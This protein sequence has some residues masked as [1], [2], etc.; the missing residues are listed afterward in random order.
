MSETAISTPKG[1]GQTVCMCA[2]VFVSTAKDA[3]PCVLGLKPD[4]RRPSDMLHKSL[5]RKGPN[6]LWELYIWG[7]LQCQRKVLRKV[8]PRVRFFLLG[9][10]LQPPGAE[11]PKMAI[12]M[13]MCLGTTQLGTKN[14]P[15]GAVSLAK[16]PEEALSPQPVLN[17]KKFLQQQAGPGLTRSL[18]FA[19]GVFS[20]LGSFPTTFYSAQRFCFDPKMAAG[21]TGRSAGRRRG[22]G[23]H[24]RPAGRLV[25]G[26]S[27]ALHPG[28]GGNQS[29]HHSKFISRKKEKKI[30]FTP[31]HR[32]PP[33]GFFLIEESCRWESFACEPSFH[34]EWP[35]FG[36]RL[37]ALL[38][39]LDHQ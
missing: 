13:E 37:I 24:S 4:T 34:M 16:V 6:P 38:R 32:G 9:N 26:G 28:D 10:A 22:G 33:Q 23:S 15:R 27:E 29:P 30:L 18:C 21:N 14:D 31:Q 39:P 19:L 11:C 8:A 17:I 35:F 36:K 7:A 1:F 20:S 25:G 5:Q 12:C 2:C 3:G